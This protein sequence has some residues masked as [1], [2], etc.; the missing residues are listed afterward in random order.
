MRWPSRPGPVG[1][2]KP[3]SGRI[4]PRQAGTSHQRGQAWDSTGRD[5]S[6]AARQHAGP[7]RMPGR[8]VGAVALH[9]RHRARSTVGSCPVILPGWDIGLLPRGPFRQP[10]A[11]WC[12]PDSTLLAAVQAAGTEIEML[13][14]QSFGPLKRHSVST[15]TFGMP[16]VESPGILVGSEEGP[17]RRVAH[18]QPGGPRRRAFVAQV[19]EF[20]QLPERAMPA[21]LGLAD[22]PAEVRARGCHVRASFGCPPADLAQARRFPPEERTAFFREADGTT[23]TTLTSRSRSEQSEGWWFQITRRVLWVTEATD[24][25]RLVEPLI[26]DGEGAPRR[27]GRGRA[28]PD[29]RPHHRA[30]RGLG[31]GRPDLAVSRAPGGHL[32][33]VAAVTATAVHDHGMPDPVRWTRSR[34][35]RSSS[36]KLLLLAF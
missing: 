26:P 6:L 32:K 11:S 14:G 34:L 17:S 35:P 21:A 13:A 9:D 24:E 33:V 7:S 15:D 3:R 2:V 19:A 31:H 16:F 20:E 23:R 30:S 8:A 18:P 10:A 22:L 29:H 25:M 36:C 27:A 4:G 1:P 5:V 12:G 28:A